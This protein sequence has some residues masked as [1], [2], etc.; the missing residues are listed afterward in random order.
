MGSGI[1][2]QEL[3]SVKLFTTKQTRENKRPVVDSCFHC[4]ENLFAIIH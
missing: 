1:E 2:R 4:G 3:N